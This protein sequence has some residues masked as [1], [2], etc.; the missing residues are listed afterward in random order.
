MYHKGEGTEQQ[1]QEAEQWIQI[2]LGCRRPLRPSDR[3]KEDTYALGHSVPLDRHKAQ[4]LF[5][6]PLSAVT[7][8]RNGS[9]R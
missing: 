1:A 6:E 9:T 3:S 7:S 4:D 8:W 2:V 5:G